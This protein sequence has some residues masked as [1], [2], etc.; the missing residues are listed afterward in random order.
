MFAFS[1]SFVIIYISDHTQALSSYNQSKQTNRTT[2]YKYFLLNLCY[3]NHF[4]NI[5]CFLK[6]EVDILLELQPLLH[7]IY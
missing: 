4:W 5:S 3:F 6:Y 7:D 2:K 1:F